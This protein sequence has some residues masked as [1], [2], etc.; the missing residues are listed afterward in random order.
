[1]QEALTNVAKHA[2]VSKAHIQLIY[3]PDQLVITISDEGSPLPR[4]RARGGGFGL[5]GMR[6]R[7]Q[8][9][10]GRLHAGRRPEGGFAVTAELPIHV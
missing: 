9:A 3:A 2:A 10:G 1:M 5:V 8:S 7:A 4:P 6:E